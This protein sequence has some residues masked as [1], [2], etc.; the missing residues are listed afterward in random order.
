MSEPRIET[1]DVLRAKLQNAITLEFTTIPAYLSGWLTIKDRDR[2]PEVSELLLS[3]ATAEMRHLAIVCNTLI[4]VGGT[5]D[6]RHAVPVYPSR[7]PDQNRQKLVKLLPF[8]KDYWELGLFVEQPGELSK[9]CR[10]YRI[11]G[12]IDWTAAQEFE[13]DTHVPLLLPGYNTIGAFYEAIIQGVER[14]VKHEGEAYVFPRGGRIDQQYTHFGGQDDIGV[15]G[16]GDAITLLRDIIDEGEGLTDQMWDEN[17]QLS[18]YYS[19][20]QLRREKSYQRDDPRCMPSGPLSVPQPDDV[21]RIPENPMMAAYEGFPEAKQRAHE[22]NEFYQKLVTNLHI[23]FTGH[24]QQID[25]AIGQMHQLEALA[26]RV[27]RCEVAP[28]GGH[29]VYAAPTFEIPPYRAAPQGLSKA[30]RL[31]VPAG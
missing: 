9:E 2:F 30:V 8:G 29:K 13:F 14:L 1:V 7:L 19:F 22:F 24:P 18:H 27:F 4:A 16:S 25:T 11:L 23:G 12:E 10:D 5:P 15:T 3:I 28:A 21:V 26:T 17:G 31:G 20:D 6:I